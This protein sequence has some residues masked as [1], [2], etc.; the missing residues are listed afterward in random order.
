MDPTI[1]VGLAGVLMSV[2]ASFVSAAGAY[3]VGRRHG[4]A[5][6]LIDPENSKPLLDL[7]RDSL[8]KVL[9]DR[10]GLTPATTEAIPAQ[11][12]PVLPAGDAMALL[13]KLI[14]KLVAPPVGP[15]P[16]A[17]DKPAA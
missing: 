11:A 3:V 13:H 15:A 16:V 9:E 14:D 12:T 8:F 5:K 6:P 17:L 2:G 10:Y 4:G 7:G 1:W